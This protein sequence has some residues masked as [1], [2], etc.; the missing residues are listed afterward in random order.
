M[1]MEDKPT[2]VVIT[3]TDLTGE[4]EIPGCKLQLVDEK[5]RIIDQWISTG[6]PHEII[7]RLEAGKTYRLIE[8]NPAPGYAYA[9]DVVF[10]VNRDGTVNQVQMKDDVTKVEI[11]KVSAETGKPLAGA[12]FEILDKN[13]AVMEHWTST[14]KAHRVEG[15]LLAGERYRLHEVSAPSGYYPMADVEFQVNDYGDVL[16]ITAENRKKEGDRGGSEYTIRIK[17]IDEEGEPLAGAAFKVTDESGRSL[18]L[19]KEEGGTLFKAVVKSTGTLT[20]TEIAAPE[21]YLKL[22]GAYRIE[23]PRTGDA[24]LMNGDESFYQDSENSYVFFAVNRKETDEPKPPGDRRVGWIT[25][26]YDRK[27]Y[28]SRKAWEQMNRREIQLTKTGD[29]FPYL[30]LEVLCAV[31]AAGTAFGIRRIRRRKK[32]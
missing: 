2:K 16:K 30:L 32:E 29:D 9:R 31:S 6:R 27:L 17:K 12:E 3:K 7:G 24:V 13:G 11:L 20:V 26:H 4:K 19:V 1:L 25:A 14:G 21:G 22:D 23:I 28:G 5:N 10:T 15:K 18:S 8:V